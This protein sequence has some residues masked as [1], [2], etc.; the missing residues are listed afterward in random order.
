[1]TNR[2]VFTASIVASLL[3]VCSSAPAWGWPWED[4]ATKEAQT[5][6]QAAV[7]ERMTK[8]GQSYFL[9]MDK[10]TYVETKEISVSVTPE[11]LTDVD[12]ANGI[13]WQGGMLVSGKMYRILEKQANGSVREKEWKDGR[14]GIPGITGLATF[15]DPSGKDQQVGFRK[16][17]GQW[18]FNR[19]DVF[20]FMSGLPNKEAF[21]CGEIGRAAEL[22]SPA[23]GAPSKPGEKPTDAT[24]T[25]LHR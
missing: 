3:W 12:K 22:A 25:T 13:E 21:T 10:S 4:A 14:A 8:C 7:Y 9:K 19:K 18:S 15:Y 6:A 23:A 2:N 20:G 5:V 24:V 17:N 11:E 16:V 1:M